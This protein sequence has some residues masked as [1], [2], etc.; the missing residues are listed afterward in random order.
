MEHKTHKL[1]SKLLLLLFL[2][3]VMFFLFS[4]TSGNNSSYEQ[5]Y[6]GNEGIV[7]QFLPDSPRSVYNQGEFIN[8]QI[9]A[10]NKGRFAY[11]A[12]IIALDGFDKQSLF[13]SSLQKQLPQLE[14]KTE[15]NPSGGSNF[16]QF[17]ESLPVKVPYGDKY[18]TTIQATSCY[19]YQTIAQVNACIIPDI[20]DIA[21]QKNVCSPRVITL[22]SQGAPVAVTQVEERVAKDIVQFL[23][24]VQNIGDGRVIQ[25]DKLDQCPYLLKPKDIDH[26]VVH[27]AIDTLG[28][29]EC[30]SNSLDKESNNIVR[31]FDNKGLIVCKFITRPDISSYETPLR[32]TLDYGYSSSI[33]KNIEIFNPEFTGR[34]I[35]N[36]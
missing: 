25:P 18:S 19:Q 2:F 24:T 9:E 8:L 3:T 12:G 33:Q 22:S 10:I 34:E 28:E 29:A 4:C 1:L 7:I 31:L 21:K 20:S 13:F 17:D 16:V 14:A 26:I 32:I 35:K 36:G 30:G 23:I 27:A 6:S 5:V 11:P 15:N